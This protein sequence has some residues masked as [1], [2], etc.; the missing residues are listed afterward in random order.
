MAVGDMDVAVE[1]N[2]EKVKS[3]SF[4]EVVARGV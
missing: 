3:K 1:E 4:K 2:K